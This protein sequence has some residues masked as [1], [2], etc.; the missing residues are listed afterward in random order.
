MSMDSTYEGKTLSLKIY[1]QSHSETIGVY[2]KGLPEGVAPDEEFT[3]SFMA[4]R[5]PGKNAWS[6]PRKEADE[7][8]FT[9][10]GTSGHRKIASVNVSMSGSGSSVSYNRFITNYQET[11]E[12]E[13]LDV[14]ASARK[15]LVG[16]QIYILLGEQLFNIQG[17][18]VK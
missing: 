12:V 4:R 14:D 17:Q 8:I 18:R 2:I 6:T 3:R 11:T 13:M 10:D 9:I 7:V 5:A 16:G 1:G 15:I